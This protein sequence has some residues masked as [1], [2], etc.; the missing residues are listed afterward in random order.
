MDQIKT[1]EAAE[2]WGLTERRVQVYLGNGK[3]LVL[4]V[5]VDWCIITLS[6]SSVRSFSGAYFNVLGLFGDYPNN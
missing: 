3:Y 4:P 5:L 2:K 6:L 1:K